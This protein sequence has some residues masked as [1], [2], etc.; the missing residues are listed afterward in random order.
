MSARNLVK[1]SGN[2]L[3]RNEPPLGSA[4]TKT[5]MDFGPIE[6]SIYFTLELYILNK[7]HDDSK[8]IIDSYIDSLF[9]GQSQFFKSVSM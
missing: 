2:C 1:R 8:K 3:V 5:A 4:V 9:L 7:F 6:L